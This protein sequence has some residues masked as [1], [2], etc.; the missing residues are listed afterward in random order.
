M[1]TSEQGDLAKKR[2][3]LLTG[4]LP[5]M[6][7]AH[8]AHHLLTALPTPL[9]PMIRSD[10]NLDYTQAGMVVSAFSLAY[11][12]GSLPSGWVTDYVG[13]R[14]MITIGTCGVAVAG[15][16]VGLSPAFMVLLAFMALMGLAAGGYHPAAPPII[17]ASVPAEKRGRALGL[18]TI[19]GGAS[20]FL[21]PILA[22][23]IAS[24]G[25]WRGA[26]IALSAVTIAF[27]IFFY[28]KIGRTFIKKAGAAAPAQMVDLA[29]PG[30]R[31]RLFLV[32]GMSTVTAAIVNSALAFVPLYAVDHFGL[33][34]TVAASF[35]S[36]YYT[37][38]FWVGPVAGY[39]ADR[40]GTVPLLM[41]VSLAVGPMVYLLTV[42]PGVP[43]YLLMIVLLGIITYTRMPIS[44]TYIVGRTSPHNRSTILGVYYFGGLEGAGVLTPIIGF[45]IDHY[46]FQTAFMA[47]AGIALLVAVIGT[48][49]LWGRRN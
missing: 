21:A 6:V 1:A 41:G 36:L 29:E 35:L 9:L 47:S 5:L 14:I 11:G 39:F 45:L 28:I 42:V 49:S 8:F 13:A 37:A 30:R 23:W 24:W 25:G 26:F 48:I 34:K 46:S 16:L 18:H 40:V 43:M 38:G 32:I 2:V 20:Y 19:G 4:I 7:I 33:S 22:A 12:F 31:K 3:G 44:E 10:F 27:G 15:V 17:S